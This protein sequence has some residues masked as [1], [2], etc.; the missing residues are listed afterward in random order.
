LKIIPV[1][2]LTAKS[3]L[4]MKITGLEYGADDY[5]YK[6]FNSR[7]L[8]VRINNLMKSRD[9]QEQLI[10]RQ[11]EVESHLKQAA[12]VQQAILVPRE[13]YLTIKGLDIDVRYLPMNRTISG[14]YYHIS[15][16]K[17]GTATIMIADA[18]GHGIQAALS[19][20]QMD[21]LNKESL[22]IKYPDERL[23]YINKM[24]TERLLSINFFTGFM[25]NVI[26]D[27]IYYSSAAHPAQYLIRRKTKDI[28]PL[29]TQGK[30]IGMIP[31]CIYEMKEEPVEQGDIL[32]L[33]TDGIFKEIDNQEIRHGEASLIKFLNQEIVEKVAQGVLTPAEI[34]NR[35]LLWVENLRLGAPKLDDITLICIS[36]N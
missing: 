1:I 9:L 26:S 34:N 12:L 29:K 2:L 23:E 24:L 6:P 8:F 25:V 4:N 13:S 18:A 14:D 36:I 10:I 28:L 30:I 17:N 33:F 21:L 20:M 11:R 15:D 32:L 5:L 3:D 16:L 7:E 35:I 22:R 19:T 27:R 31:G